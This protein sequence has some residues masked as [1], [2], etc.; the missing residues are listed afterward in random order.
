MF[1]LHQ[2]TTYNHT[3]LIQKLNKANATITNQSETN[4]LTKDKN[5]SYSLID[6]LLYQSRVNGS[7]NLL[8]LEPFAPLLLQ[9]LFSAVLPD[10]HHG[11]FPPSPTFLGVHHHLVPVP[12]DLGPGVPAWAIRHRFRENRRKLYE[13]RSSAPFLGVLNWGS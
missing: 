6:L 9:T 3:T 8:R 10:L 7:R 12:A 11:V 4:T 13:L 1:Q 2:H 5:E